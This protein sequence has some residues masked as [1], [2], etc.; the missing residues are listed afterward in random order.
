MQSTIDE[1]LS[2]AHARTQ[3]NGKI[4][5]GDL[6]PEEAHAILQA[7]PKA[8]LIDV[9]SHPEL[10]FAGLVPGCCHVPWQLY[11]GMTPNPNF[12]AEITQHAQPDD[13]AGN[14]GRLEGG[15][16]ALAA[17][18]ALGG[19]RRK[20]TPPQSGQPYCWQAGQKRAFLP[21][22]AN[23]SRGPPQLGQCPSW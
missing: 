20:Q 16:S 2:R 21:P 4:H 11:P 3:A 5:A 22:T 1:I 12:T 13:R 18:V 10:D 17:Q 9:R 19:R 15:R 6:T 23:V 7:N 8:L 14:G